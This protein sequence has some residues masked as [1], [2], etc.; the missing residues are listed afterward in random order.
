MRKVALVSE[1]ASPLGALGGVDSGG[2]N[3]YVAQIASHLARLGW[4]VDVFTRADAVGL[5]ETMLASPGV[6]VVHVPAG[7][8]NFVRKEDMLPYMGDFADFVGRYAIRERYDILHANFFMSGMVAA[9]VKRAHRIPFAV[10]FHALGKVRR[11]YQ[12]DS[13]DFPDERFSI[14]ERVVAE[15]DRIVAECPQDREDLVTLYG[16]DP[17]KVSVVPCGFDPEEL[18]PMDRE[19]ARRRLGVPSDEH[20]ILQ[21][22]RMVPRKG[23]ETVVRAIAD[24]RDYHGIAANLLVV[25]GESA[26]ADARITPEIGRLTEIA[27]SCGVAS[28]LRFA[29]SK[30]RSELRGYYSAADVFAT[31]PWYEPFGITPLEAMACET[32]VVGS[33]VGGIKYTVLDGKTGYLVPPKDSLSLAGRLAQVLSD[34]AL[35]RRLGE[36]GRRR[37]LQHFTWAHVARTLDEVYEGMRPPVAPMLALPAEQRGSVQPVAVVTASIE[38]SVAALLACRGEVCGRVAAAASLVGECLDGGGK[39]LVCGNGGSAADAQHFAGELVC[40]FRQERAGIPVL[41]LGTDPSVTTAWS[42]D[43][44]FHELFARQVEAFGGPGDVLVALSTSG[45]SENVR[46][47]MTAARE[48]GMRTVAFLG[49]DGGDA[50][51][52]AD[53]AVLVPSNDTPRIQEAQMTLLHALAELVE[54]RA[55]AHAEETSAPPAS[56]VPVGSATKR[57]AGGSEVVDHASGLS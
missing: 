32:P 8:A 18:W 22:G 23:V 6:R 11:L 28:R 49:G 16:A 27:E 50:L 26:E 44:G 53:I 9:E 17:E 57:K 2:Q 40:R 36:E 41:A 56:V 13:D 4:V 14:E 19:E 55:A 38:S 33:A 7:P 15:A 42:N 51:P 30:A 45:R 24:L 21:L 29:G 31:V 10:T 34:R 1:H 54:T 46:R 3:V 20:L 37:V 52:L 43:V 48:R 47:A 5:P 35:A 39:V 12:G 25:G